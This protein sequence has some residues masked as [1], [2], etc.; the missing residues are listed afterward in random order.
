MLFTETIGSHSQIFSKVSATNIG[1]GQCL[2]NSTIFYGFAVTVMTKNLPV[3]LLDTPKQL[4]LLRGNDF[5]YTILILKCNDLI[6]AKN[7]NEIIYTLRLSQHVILMH[8]L[9]YSYICTENFVLKNSLNL[10]FIDIL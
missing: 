4:T 1:Q 8:L 9:K 6:L 3:N 2:S 5:S 10:S 7:A